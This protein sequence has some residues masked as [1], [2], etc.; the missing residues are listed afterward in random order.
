[1]SDER[2]TKPEENGRVIYRRLEA[3][4]DESRRE[5]ARAS[6]VKAEDRRWFGEA[7]TARNA[8]AQGGALPSLMPLL[9]GFALLLVVVWGLGDRSVHRLDTV[10]LESVAN[11]QRHA[12]TL[13]LLLQLRASLT[14]VN[15]EVRSRERFSALT[16]AATD[17][18]GAASDAAAN[19]NSANSNTSGAGAG[20]NSNANSNRAPRIFKPPMNMPLRNARN[21]LRD[22][23]PKIERYPLAAT[24]KWQQFRRDLD[25]YLAVTEDSARYGLEGYEKFRTVDGELNDILR[26]ADREHDEVQSAN[27]NLRDQAARDIKNLT[28]F[29]LTIAAL[30][31]LLTLLEAYRRFRQLRR[32]LDAVRR[33]RQFSGQILE[34]MVSA[35]AAIDGR[36]RLRSANQLFFNL[37]PNAKVGEAVVEESESKTEP[38][39]S[40]P[41]NNVSE[42]A[43]Q[44]NGANAAEVKTEDKTESIAASAPLS[45]EARRL[46]QSV[47]A[48]PVNRAMYQGRWTLP[49]APNHD[50][51]NVSSPN[52]D[53][54]RTFDVYSSPLE[55]GGEA[56]QILTL[57]DVTEAAQAEAEL[58]QQQA[59][60][61]VGQATAQVAHEIRNPLGS[62]RLGV[63]MLRDMTKDSEAIS[64]ID[65]VERGI[66]HLS[67][68]T[69]DVTQFSRR[70][71]LNIAPADINQIL[72]DA[73]ELVADKLNEKNAPV[74]KHYAPESLIADCDEDQL[75]QVF[76]NLFANAL[77]AS[78]K[79][80]PIEIKTERIAARGER[81]ALGGNRPV[82]TAARITIKDYGSGMDAQTRRRI[83]EPFFTT[84]KRGTGLGMAIVKKIIEQHGGRIAVE[85]APGKGSTFYVEI[86]LQKEG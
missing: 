6:Q 59:L 86:P 33:E 19:A 79:E 2:Q 66:E 71:Q 24:P 4:D 48:A 1:M 16:G 34:G 36:K 83:F 30:V 38:A 3:A 56:G 77:D 53:G 27:K 78:A 67:K 37:F 39:E 75:R 25:D 43:P 60:A 12:D 45:D 14:K 21:E 44:T 64:T 69:I 28:W 10:N 55:I 73:L 8:L 9:I 42:G 18:G 32:S 20:A 22:A 84:K 76:V 82:R 80:S 68:L 23:L 61:A 65:L 17:S 41:A 13:S 15:N 54:S 47:I 35:V 11:E 57:V 72:D 7:R 50:E 31:A 58:R 49:A 70:T 51:M 52:D 26:D 5:S 46:L 29:A 63:A 62:I 81:R 74:I 85:S 40:E